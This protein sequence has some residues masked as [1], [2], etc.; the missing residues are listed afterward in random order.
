MAFAIHVVVNFVMK[1]YPPE[2]PTPDELRAYLS[3]EAGTWALVHGL[4]YLAVAGISIFAAA[5][6]VRTS[7]IVPV[8]RTGWSVVG[9]FGAGLQ[10][11]NLLITNGVETLAFLD[12]ERLSNS[13]ELF[14]LLFH[15]TRVLFTA[16]VVTWAVFILGFSVAGW[17]TGTLPK[18]LGGLGGVCALAGVVSAVSIGSVM[19]GGRAVIGIEIAAMASL[20][21][22]LSSGVYLLVRGDA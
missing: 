4:R 14:W 10:C 8:S 1:T 7:W 18:L 11:A 2:S 12:Y 16:E 17:K 20:L 6:F 15:A 3:E 13:P 5:M 22:F 19:N 21:W 9:L